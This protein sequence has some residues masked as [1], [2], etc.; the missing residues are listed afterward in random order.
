[1]QCEHFA[2]AI[3]LHADVPVMLAWEDPYQSGNLAP[4]DVVEEMI[5]WLKTATGRLPIIRYQGIGSTVIE[6][7]PRINRDPHDNWLFHQEY[8]PGVVP[9]I[10]GRVE[11]VWFKGSEDEL[12]AF[13]RSGA[14][15]DLERV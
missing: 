10:A 8:V 13:V 11:H 9:G 1:M 14:V 7:C 6:P 15:P 3:G 2:R 4:V 5:R 12:K